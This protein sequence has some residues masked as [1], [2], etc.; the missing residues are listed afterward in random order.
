MKSM[1]A[2]ARQD[3]EMHMWQSWVEIEYYFIQV[4]IKFATDSKIDA[5]GLWDLSAL[6]LITSAH[7][8]SM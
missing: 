6:L 8:A 7:S 2:Y 1:C 4:K 5:S 3:T